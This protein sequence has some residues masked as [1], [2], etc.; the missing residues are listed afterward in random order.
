MNGSSEKV[1]DIRLAVLTYIKSS[2]FNEISNKSAM[3]KQIKDVSI[4]IIGKLM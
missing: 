2:F 3:N 4:F 1:S